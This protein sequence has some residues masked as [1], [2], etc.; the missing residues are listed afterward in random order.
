MIRFALAAL[1]LAAPAAAQEAPTAYDRAIAAGYKA[2][3]TCSAVFV[4][5]R[6]PAQVDALEL[7]GTYRDYR[8]RVTAGDTDAAWVS[9]E[10]NLLHT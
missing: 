10:E 9:F 6:T 4:A 1:L 5:G 2:L 7:T 3:T 8:R